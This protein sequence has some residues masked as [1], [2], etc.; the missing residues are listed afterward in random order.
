M[1]AVS[2]VLCAAASAVLAAPFNAVRPRASQVTPLS[3]TDISNLTSF[4]QF[5]RLPVLVTLLAIY[6]VVG[7][8]NELVNWTCGQACEA[9]PNFEVALTG[10]MGDAVQFCKSEPPGDELFAHSSRVF[11]GYYPETNS[12]IISHEG[13]DPVELMSD[14]TDLNVLKGSLNSTLFPG[15]PSNIEVHTGFRDEHAITADAIREATQ[16]LIA[17]KNATQ[18]TVVGHSL[19]GALAELDALSLRLILP[20]TVGVNAYTFGTP[21]VGD[22]NFVTFFDSQV[23]DFKRVNNQKA[24]LTGLP[25]SFEAH[26]LLNIVPIVP[27]RFLGFDHPQGEIHFV[28]D[29]NDTVVACPGNDDSTDPQ[30]QIQTVPSILDGDILNH[31]G[32]YN[33]IHLGTIFCT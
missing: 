25:F 29:N 15:A 28:S 33:G 17:T 8:V 18:V 27:G 11:V 32:P 10:G 16:S 2:L 4:I 12:V 20:K 6:Q 1:L 26:P 30:C 3:T 7:P 23:P 31:L 9:N 19:G 22:T 14:L 24:K 13:T 5:A 21:R